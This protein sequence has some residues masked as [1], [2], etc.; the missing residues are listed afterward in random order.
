MKICLSS[1][2]DNLDGQ[3]DPR[4]GRCA[5]LL[6][7]D[8]D[9]QQF[10]AIPNTASAATGGAGIQAA[11]TIINKQA[12]TVITGNIGPN[13][14]KAL[15]A[16]GVEVLIEPS[17]KIRVVLEKFQSGKLKKTAAATVEGHAGTKQSQEQ[18]A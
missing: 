7:V 3:L 12:K 16:A 6:I 10:E 11:Q 17:E 13:A 14:F 15:S 4:F 2:A 1:T 8:T 5:Y 9:T 18:K